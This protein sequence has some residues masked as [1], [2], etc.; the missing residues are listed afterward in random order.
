MYNPDPTKNNHF[1]KNVNMMKTKTCP[2]S[3]A[4]NWWQFYGAFSSTLSR[5]QGPLACLLSFFFFFF[6]NR[7]IL[8]YNSEILGKEADY[9]IVFWSL[10]PQYIQLSIQTTE[11]SRMGKGCVNQCSKEG[12]IVKSEYK[13]QLTWHKL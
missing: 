13:S 1:D 5:A 12:N 10:H 3:Y 2:K 11:F 9:S 8:A 6:L 7:M 4:W